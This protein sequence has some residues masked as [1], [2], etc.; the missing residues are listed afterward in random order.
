MWQESGG[1][2]CSAHRPWASACALSEQRSALGALL[3]P[4]AGVGGVRGRLGFPFLLDRDKQCGTWSRRGVG[5]LPV[6]RG[7]DEDSSV[8]RK[9]ESDSQAS[10]AGLRVINNVYPHFQT[11]SLEHIFA[12]LNSKQSLLLSTFDEIE[13]SN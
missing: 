1:L 10:K 5:E 2:L 3:S 8:R 13:A 7:G 4:P 6:P 12:G 11:I 9:F